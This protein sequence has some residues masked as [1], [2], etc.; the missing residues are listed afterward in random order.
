MVQLISL[1]QL[2]LDADVQPRETMSSGLISEYA[3]LYREGHDFPP[4]K[5]FKDGRKYWVADGFHRTSAAREAGLS[6]IAV[7][8]EPGTKRNAILYACASNKHGK[9]RTNEDKYR[10]VDR[11]LVDPEW[12]TWGDGEIALHCGVGRKLVLARRNLSCPHGQ[13]TRKIHR[14]HYI[15]TMDTSHIGQR[16]GSSV[17][18]EVQ[19]APSEFT[20]D[21]DREAIEAEFPR[22]PSTEIF[23]ALDGLADEAFRKID[24]SPF[25]EPLAEP[26]YHVSSY[27]LWV[28][29]LREVATMLE[30][31]HQMGG[32]HAITQ[33]LTPEQVDE[34]IR[35]VCRLDTHLRALLN[36]IETMG[37]V[38]DIKPSVQ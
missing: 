34:V 1:K 17:E 21:L 19:P 4:I 5:V 27:V 16:H 32:I 22:Q 36:Q 13:D 29:L 18:I 3:K 35:Q 26:E 12:S 30:K 6:E 7:E 28:R 9:V 15:Y 37:L 2:I 25:T 24:L 10:A 11:L 14:G 20:D 38:M 33:N 31:L 8:V 23:D